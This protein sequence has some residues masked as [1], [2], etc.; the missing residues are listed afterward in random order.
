[1]PYS[2]KPSSP[3]TANSIHFPR[4]GSPWVP[5]VLIE[6]AHVASKNKDTYS[7]A[8][9]RRIGAR[10]SKKRALVALG[11]TIVGMIYHMLSRNVPYTEQGGN[12]FDEQERQQV[13]RRLVRRLERL[14]D[15]VT[16]QS[17]V[18]EPSPTATS[19]GDLNTGIFSR[20]SGWSKPHAC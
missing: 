5:H 18:R 11:H 4:K 12:Y 9:Y 17:T 7:A 3:F 1:M 16:L 6:I 13:E 20:V 2:E 8:Q 10:R 19:S 14:G 15:E